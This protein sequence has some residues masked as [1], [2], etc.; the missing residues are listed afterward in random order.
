MDCAAGMG[1]AEMNLMQFWG[2]KVH[3]DEVSLCWQSQS[4]QQRRA[5]RPVSNG[6][7]AG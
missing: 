4:H 3:V 6:A 2:S 1:E 5:A 7:A